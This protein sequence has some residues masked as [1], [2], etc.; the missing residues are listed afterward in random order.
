ML[1][2]VQC[3][4][5][6][7]PRRAAYKPVDSRWSMSSCSA[8]FWNIMKGVSFSVLKHKHLAIYNTLTEVYTL[9]H[10]TVMIT[11][12]SSN[13]GNA[14][15]SSII[16]PNLHQCIISMVVMWKAS[17]PPPP[18]QGKNQTRCGHTLRDK[19]LNIKGPTNKLMLQCNVPKHSLLRIATCVI[20]SC[21]STLISG[22][23]VFKI[24]GPLG[25]PT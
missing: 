7:W 25:Q 13:W 2:P 6:R 3:Q 16:P 24:F 23:P 8:R 1:L 11:V 12:R 10:Y 4:W 14:L 20:W 18:P 21:C 19:F 22:L 15:N 5:L 9:R 17:F